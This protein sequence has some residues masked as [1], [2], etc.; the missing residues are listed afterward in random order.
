MVVDM[1]LKTSKN[2]FKRGEEVIAGGVSSPIRA[3]M[4]LDVDPMVV[5]AG[6][7]DL[8]WDVDGK[9]LIDY[10]MSWGALLHGHAHDEIVRVASERVQKGSSFGIATEEEEAL[11]REVVQAVSSIDQV[12][13][14]SSGT[15]AVMTAVRMARGYTGRSTMIKF[16]GNYHGHSDGFLVKAG[17]G[18]AQVSRTSSSAG[19]PDDV[20][21]TTLSLP[22][23]DVD[24]IRRALRD[25]T[26]AKDVAAVVLEPIAAN[27][28]VVP[29]S[30]AFLRCLRE[31]T[32]RI[33]ALLI[34]DEV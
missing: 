32:E 2:I 3:F 8:I 27:M 25:P 11:A 28:G 7:G 12:R 15:E 16:N 20:V 5:R 29:A 14:V 34:F 4:G 23:N 1:T 31:E 6:K 18:V 19:V 33:G 9:C 13:F 10:C 26:I 30:N 22:Y 24:A 21:K 17:S